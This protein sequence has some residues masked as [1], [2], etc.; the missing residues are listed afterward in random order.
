M[1]EARFVG[2]L[3]R[4]DETGRHRRRRR[5]RLLPPEGDRTA[6]AAPHPTVLERCSVDPVVDHAAHDRRAGDR[7][8][9]ALGGRA[10]PCSVGWLTDMGELAPLLEVQELDTSV[11]QLR[12]RLATHPLRSAVAQAE[13]E[14]ATLQAE[15]AERR[16]ERD[17]LLRQ[18]RRWDDEVTKVSTKRAEIDGRLYGG[19]VTSPKELVALQADAESL[20]RRQTELEDH[21]LEVMELVEAANAGVDESAASVGQVEARLEDR[22]QE[23]TAATAEL[24][25]ELDRVSNERRAAAEPL[26]PSLLTR[27]EAMRRDLGGVAVARLNGSTCEGCHLTLSAMTVDQLRKL[28]DD[29]VPLCEE[30]GRILVR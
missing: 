7:C 8:T 23:L 16:A 1:L 29:A 2:D 17:E 26:D 9:P 12:H 15:L 3:H 19:T 18:Q 27:Y 24:E 14:L 30:C 6:Q 4:S 10:T 11:D 22:R 13:R 20:H 5:A 21:E 28:P 25:V